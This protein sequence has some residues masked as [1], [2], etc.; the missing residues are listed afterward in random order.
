MDG[1]PMRQCQGTGLLFLRDQHV[2]SSGV[3]MPNYVV[4]KI[5]EKQVGNI[6]F[7]RLRLMF[8]YSC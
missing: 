2:E 8:C 3:L 5:V 4:M 6:R 1:S 7:V